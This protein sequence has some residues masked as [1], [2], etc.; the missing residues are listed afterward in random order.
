L[1][2]HEEIARE[3]NAQLAG[4]FILLPIAP[5]IGDDRDVLSGKLTV[6]YETSSYIGLREL[7]SLSPSSCLKY[8]SQPT[9]VALTS[10]QVGSSLKYTP[11]VTSMR[12]K[13]RRAM[14]SQ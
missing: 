5:P 4:N 9:F 3:G 10:A 12:S 6:A 1:K 13:R 7:K 14:S 11:T 2:L 8:I